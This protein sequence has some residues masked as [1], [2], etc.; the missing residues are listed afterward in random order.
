MGLGLRVASVRAPSLRAAGKA[1]GRT[2][3]VRERLLTTRAHS[4]PPE[5]LREELLPDGALLTRGRATLLP[6]TGFTVPVST[7]TV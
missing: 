6:V 3:F 2:L 4:V 5:R 7:L 1:P